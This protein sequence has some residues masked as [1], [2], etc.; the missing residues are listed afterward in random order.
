ML[1]RL[2]LPDGAVEDLAFA[3]I[4]RRPLQGAAPDA[5]RLR[6]DE[7]ALGIEA[8][9]QVMEAPALLADAVLRRHRQAVE[10]HRVRI[11][12]RA[13]HLRNLGRREIAPVKIRVEERQAV[14][15]APALLLRRGAGDQQ[16]LVGLLRR[17]G[18]ELLP[19]DDIAALA[20]RLRPRLEAG[21]VEAGI[22]LSD[23][24]TGLL[25]AG[26]QLR[27]HAPALLVRAVLDD[28]LGAENVEMDRGT[29][30]HPGTGLG[31]RL[32]QD[33]RLD[34][35]EP[36]AAELLRHGDAEPSAF[37]HGA[38]EVVR[39][40]ALRIA[41]APIVEIESGAKAFHRL[42]HLVVLLAPPELHGA[43][44]LRVSH[45]SLLYPFSISTATIAPGGLSPN[46]SPQ[47]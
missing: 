23:R 6:G 20:V 28:G 38:V 17:C 24:E 2:V 1:D 9:E 32:H 5:D 19:V 46:P 45:R 3:R 10:E 47:C 21:G 11:D 39:E 25:L 14:E 44:P 43:A 29:A 33:R 7:D 40:L 22:R 4:V 12:R 27:Q 31:H 16:H 30:A 35:A 26:D 18:P 15:S 34:N 41:V 42:A 36:R 13:A 8:V 37:R